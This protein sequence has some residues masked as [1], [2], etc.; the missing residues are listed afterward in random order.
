MT[1]ETGNVTI[2]FANQ[3][4]EH[5]K[6][7]VDTKSQEA[8]AWAGETIGASQ[9]QV[10]QVRPTEVLAA[11]GSGTAK[12]VLPAAPV[13]PSAP[14]IGTVAAAPL[15]NRPPDLPSTPLLPAVPDLG[16]LDA[17]D[18]ISETR[19]IQGDLIDELKQALIEFAERW[20]PP[21]Q[22]LEKATAWLERAL[23][24][25]A[26]IAPDVEAKIWERDRARLTA[27]SLRAEDEALTLWASR[28][29][30]LPPGAMVNQLNTIRQGLANA[31]SQQ[32]RD[33]AIKA[34]ANELENA[35]FAVQ[36]ATALRTAAMAA[37][38]NFIN[39]LASSMSQAIQLS[40]SKADA[41]A[42]IASAKS[43]IFSAEVDGKTK[44]YTSVAGANADHYRAETGAQADIYRAEVEGFK[45]ETGADVEVFRSVAAA[46]MD[47]FR[48]LSTAMTD[49][50]R[51]ESQ[52]LDLDLRAKT[53]T[54]QLDL[55]AQRLNQAAE[56]S[57]IQEQV[58]AFA[59]NAS[60][61]ASQCA[62]AIQGLRMSAGVTNGSQTTM[63][64]RG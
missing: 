21:G 57:Q 20:F 36:Q 33:I 37:A 43:A 39:A 22:Y 10:R 3:I 40:T 18:I 13:L 19:S 41:L 4:I 45:A 9:R 2:D 64:I 38:V 30:R 42:R 29:Y 32:S 56:L 62:A 11:G 48:T 61:L 7:L 8:S 46:E 58:R 63:Q 31:M 6:R 25:G 28:G 23:D 60:Q 15:L 51:A 27:E 26:T 50:Y 12:P 53:T 5:I 49:L 14:T 59:A 34:H 24:G 54:A 1:V 52:T 17:G 35:K 44:L 47:K 16:G 55:D